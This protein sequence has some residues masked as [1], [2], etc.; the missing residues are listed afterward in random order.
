MSRHSRLTNQS[1]LVQKTWPEINK[2]FSTKHMTET[3]EFLSQIAPFY[4][5][6]DQEIESIA[7]ALVKVSYTKDTL[8]FI[9]GTTKIDSLYLVWQGRLERFIISQEEPI[10]RGFL[11]P[12]NTYGG[13]SLLFNDGVSIRTVKSVEETI[14]YRLP[15]DYFFEL[16]SRYKDFKSYFTESFGQ[17]M[18]EKPYVNYIAQCAR[19]EETSPPGILN[20]TLANILSKEIISCPSDLSIQEA[21]RLM[22]KQQ[23]SALV[24]K[25]N[26][27]NFGL[28]T[29]HDLRSKVVAQNLPIDRPIKEIASQPLIKIPSD[30]QVFEAILDMMQHNVKHL[31][32]TRD[33]RLIGIATEKDLLMAQGYSPVFLRHEIQRSSSVEEISKRHQQLPDLIKSL[34][35]GGAKAEHLN[36][37]ITSIS[38]AILEKLVDFALDD[39]GPPPARFSFIIM[40]SEGRKEQTL[41]TD[42]DNAIIFEDISG[43]QKDFVQNYFLKL[44]EKICTWLDKAGYTFCKNNLMAQNPKW[45]QPLQTWK[46]YFWEWIHKSEPEAILNSS[47]F[48]DFRLGYGDSSLAEELKRYLVQSLEGWSGFLRYLAEDVLSFKPPLDFFGNLAV[49]SKGEHKNALNLKGPM[50]LIVDFA[51]IYSLKYGIYPTNTLERLKKLDQLQVIDNQDYEELLHAYC[52]LMEMR[53]HHQVTNIS[54]QNILP[55]NYIIPKELTQFERQSL[56]EAFKRIRIAQGKLRVDFTQFIF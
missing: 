9:Q 4:I 1:N 6:P 50:R 43:N 34:V 45:C 37:I 18:L 19:C 41:K 28:V 21:A 5:L 54:D 53:L 11:G 42:Q 23:R 14:F 49:E 39:L 12:A 36:R 38:D 20:Q 35:Q 52:F 32:V 25:E 16:C 31:G 10:L 46:N 15:K 55:D 30:T 24:V 8:I 44:G 29:D 2:I 40:G 17:K 13:L 51:R 56:K 48:F 26:G 33:D 47:I 7:Q 3:K 27:H 22:D